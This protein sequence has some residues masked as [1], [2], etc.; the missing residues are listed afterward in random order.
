MAMKSGA[1]FKSPAGGSASDLYMVVDSTVGNKQGWE[2]CVDRRNCVFFAISVHFRFRRCLF[3]I[4]K[5]IFE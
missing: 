4:V 3:F 1:S 2:S 5:R